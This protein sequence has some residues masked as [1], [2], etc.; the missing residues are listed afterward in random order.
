MKKIS[1][2]LLVFLFLGQLGLAQTQNTATIRGQVRDQ[3][4]AAVVG[5]EVEIINLETGAKRSLTTDGNGYYTVPG[6][7]LTGRYEVKV[8]KSGFETDDLKDVMLRA[9]ESATLDVTLHPQGD[10]SVITVYG[11]TD[12]VRSDS[13]Q[14]GTRLDLQK[15]ENTPVFG[16][17]ITNLFQLNS[18]V[19]TARGTGDLFLNNYLFVANGSGR[20]QTTFTVDGSTG[21]DAWGRQTI[22]TNVP[23]SSLQ[24]VSI[25]TNS[26]SAEYG[27]T[28]GGVVNIVTQSGTNG[29]HGNLLGVWRPGGIQATAPLANRRT[30]DEL[31][32]ISGI[33][34][35]PVIKDRTHFL[36]AA[37]YNQQDRDAVIT[38]ALAPGLFSG[39]YQQ[40]LFQ[41]RIDHRLN[42]AHSLTAKFNLERFDDTNPS[43]AVGG[44][45]LPSAARTFTRNTYGAQLTETAIFTPNLVN[46]ARFQFLLGSPITQFQPVTP[47]TQFVRPGLGTEGDSRFANL[48][49]H[50]YQFADTVSVLHGKHDLK[51][52][53]DAVYS[54][55]GGVGQEFGTGFVLGQ[56]TLNPGVRTPISQLTVKDVQRFQQTFGDASYNVSQWLVSLFVQ[57]NF[58][59]RRDLTLNLGLRYER[60]SFTDDNNNVAPRIGFAYNPRGDAK[61]VI[62]GGYGI[63]YSQLRANI[64][65]GYKIN[66]PAGIFSFSAAPG[67]FGFPTSIGPLPAFP[68]GANLPARDITV[69]VGDAASLSKYFDVNKLRFYPKELL[70]PYSQLASFGF[71]RELPGKLFVSADY[72]YQHTIRIDRPVDL[73]SPVAF[74]ATRPGQVRSAAD[75]DASRPIRP[76]LNG[77]RRILATVN[78][79]EGLYNALQINVRKQLTHRFS[80]LASYT[81][82]HTINTVE[83][84]APGQDPVDANLL[85]KPERAN[86][87]LD[88]RHKAVFS[89]FYRFPLQF[90]A[91]SVITLATGRP[92]NITTGVDNN[93]DGANTD[94]PI[95]N[96]QLLGRNAGR[97]SDIYDVQLFVEKE[98]TLRENIKI[99]VRAEAYNLFNHNNIYGRNGTY[100]NDPTGKPAATLGQPVGGI[101]SVDPGRQFQF[102]GR[103]R[104]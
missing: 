78:L 46:E 87:L 32:Q 50:Q 66:G 18:A 49:N 7:N 20:R 30:E 98:F 48:G 90:T 61:T 62:R 67:Q 58:R 35:G 43:D 93:G 59:V 11:T 69:R 28:T 79:G 22:F 91:G 37:E 29:F 2:L 39:T 96:G 99:S 51:F 12:G 5:A 74:V 86:S 40:T 75:A 24:E 101:A 80:A 9:G 72:V 102:T 45:N 56:F 26:F 57:D 71:E 14:L 60:Q 73:N 94:R 88:Q 54:T 19:R 52:G 82:S 83:P 25:L 17:K 38:S 63:Y 21:D 1:R 92:Y 15:I 76:A 81:W 4:G 97:G 33:F 27:R 103:I 41:G 42:D 104:F 44:L 6:L 8:S 36:L 84:D 77:Y 70:N 89:G 95:V 85:G 31:A 34:S 100:G 64:A 53:G 65:A 13:P 68:P 55:S 23:L 10:R 16:R 47:S 3:S